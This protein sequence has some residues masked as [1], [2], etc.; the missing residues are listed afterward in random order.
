MTA[1]NQSI[2][3]SKIVSNYLS[4]YLSKDEC[5]RLAADEN[6]VR[7]RT[8]KGQAQR[9]L[10]LVYPDTK[11]WQQIIQGLRDLAIR[12]GGSVGFVVRKAVLEYVKRH[13]PGNSGLPL[14]HWADKNPVPFSEAAK[15]KLAPKPPEPDYKHMSVPE[16]EAQ[17]KRRF[18]SEADCMVIRFWIGKKQQETRTK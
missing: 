11:A 4:I 10:S 7:Q 13:H 3:Q 5:I 6:P 15:E 16:L 14:T 2:N 9:P 12:D 1:I 18:L 8:G 17:L